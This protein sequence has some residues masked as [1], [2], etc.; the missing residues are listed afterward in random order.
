[1]SKIIPK[2][3]AFCSNEEIFWSRATW[4]CH[5]QDSEVAAKAKLGLGA[6]FDDGVRGTLASQIVWKTSKIS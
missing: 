5:G 4:S 3:I 2:L 1:M 6:P